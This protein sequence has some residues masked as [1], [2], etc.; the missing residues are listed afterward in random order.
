[1]KDFEKIFAG[2][3]GATIGCFVWAFIA[4]VLEKRLRQPRRKGAKY[5]WRLFFLKIPNAPLFQIFHTST[6]FI[7]GI[8]SVFK[9]GLVD[10]FSTSRN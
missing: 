2:T 5:T 1:M 9:H 10:S 8:A 4:G 7:L 3:F 6:D